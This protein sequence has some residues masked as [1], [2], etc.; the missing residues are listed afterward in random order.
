MHKEHKIVFVISTDQPLISKDTILKIIKEH[1]KT[2]STITIGT[3]KLPD[4][5][6]WRSS[7]FILAEL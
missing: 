4:F 6:D 1:L 7:F 2:K 5:K 3:I